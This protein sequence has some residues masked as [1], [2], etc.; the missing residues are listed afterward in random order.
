VTVIA[1][2][3]RDDFYTAEFLSAYTR[4]RENP[5]G[6]NELLEQAAAK[7]LL[8]SLEGARVL[9]LGCGMGIFCRYC[10]ERGAQ[11]VFGVDISPR[12]LEYAR[13][14][15]AVPGVEYRAAPAE[16]VTFERGA[17]DLVVSSYC[18][19]F[20]EDY[21][22]M[23]TKIFRWLSP[24]GTLVASFDHP[25]ITAKRAPGQWARDETGREHWL[26]NDY[27]EEGR[28]VRVMF[29]AQVVKYHRRVST[30]INGLLDHGFAVTR[31]LE[32]DIAADA[33]GDDPN[34][35]A[36]L[37]RPSFLMVRAVRP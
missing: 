12:I 29:A 24:G 8:P 32:P 6:Y 30:L 5:R 23:L 26:V 20:V 16:G 18:L 9:D 13:T 17:F 35:K 19:N 31:V 4:H 28:R 25:L 22:A 3:D 14:H 37:V 7:S 11:S 1:S 21:G 15:H 36:E 27:L 33:V 34:L 10:M 2:L